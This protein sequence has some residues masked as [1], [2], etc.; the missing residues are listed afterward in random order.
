MELRF[1]DYAQMRNGNG[2][3]EI[4]IPDEP[5]PAYFSRENRLARPIRV[6]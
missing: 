2:D 6:V 4:G 5:P 3:G 1:K